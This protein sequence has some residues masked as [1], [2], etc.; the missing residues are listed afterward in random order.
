MTTESGSQGA[1]HGSGTSSAGG[2]GG[3][4]CATLR[5]T[6]TL[7]QESQLLPVTDP[8]TGVPDRGTGAATRTSGTRHAAGAILVVLALGLAFRL[9]IAQQLPGSGFQVDLI[10]F[11]GWAANLAAQ[12]PF[13]FYSRPFFHDYTPGYL[14]VLWVVGLVERFLPTLDLIKVPAILADLVG[15]YLIWAMTL[16]IGASRRA[17]LVGAGLYLFVPITWFDSVVWGQV[18]SVGVVFVLLG[19]RDLWR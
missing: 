1:L 5:S 3:R 16:E 6:S 14:Y 10:S 9:I 2:L 15:A 13:G 18:D 12:G 17:A 7:V 8:A 4:P 11:R 19:L